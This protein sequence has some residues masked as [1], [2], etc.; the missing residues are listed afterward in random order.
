MAFSFRIV[1]RRI[2]KS[3]LGFFAGLPV[4]IQIIILVPSRKVINWLDTYSVLLY[5]VRNSESWKSFLTGFWGGNGELGSH[6]LAAATAGPR[7]RGNQARIVFGRVTRAGLWFQTKTDPG[8]RPWSPSYAETLRRAINWKE[9]RMQRKPR[10]KL[11]VYLPPDLHRAFKRH[12]QTQGVSMAHI[13]RT[14]VEHDLATTSR[15]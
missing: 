14:M 13:I 4:F 5:V 8:R 12:S 6:Y 3:V 15:R 1:A 11:K 10:P 2:P 9:V 7:E